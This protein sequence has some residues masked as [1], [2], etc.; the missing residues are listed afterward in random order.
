M[1]RCLNGEKLELVK[2]VRGHDWHLSQLVGGVG[3][4]KEQKDR[5]TCVN[6]KSLILGKIKALQ[7]DVLDFNL[8]HRI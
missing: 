3:S 4:G 5:R 7:S 6:E 1:G 8:E 2:L